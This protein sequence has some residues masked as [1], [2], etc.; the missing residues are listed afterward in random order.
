MLALFPFLISYLAI[1]TNDID[2]VLAPDWQLVEY[3]LVSYRYRI[4]I[5]LFTKSADWS[6][7]LRS[8]HFFKK[9]KHAF[10]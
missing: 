10:V 8:K 1:K 4:D 6:S 9:N 5:R 7:L 3:G 2:S